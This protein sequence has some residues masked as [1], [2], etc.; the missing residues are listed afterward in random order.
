MYRSGIKWFLNWTENIWTDT[1]ASSLLLSQPT[2]I[3]YATDFVG[4][5]QSLHQDTQI[6]C[7]FEDKTHRWNKIKYLLNGQFTLFLATR[8]LPYLCHSLHYF[9]CHLYSIFKLCWTVLEISLDYQPIHSPVS[10]QF[11]YSR[12][13]RS[14][15]ARGYLLGYPPGYKANKL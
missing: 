13:S 8:S 11:I 15:T 9:S 5:Y 14:F 7:F 1:K 6:K 3:C 4:I 12:F 10:L 2:L